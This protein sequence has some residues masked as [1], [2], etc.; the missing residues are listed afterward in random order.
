M[1]RGQ[2]RTCLSPEEMNCDVGMLESGVSQQRVAGI[3]N[4][5]PNEES[6]SNPRISIAQTWRRT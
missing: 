3:L 2:F 1:P 6:S 4:D 5:I